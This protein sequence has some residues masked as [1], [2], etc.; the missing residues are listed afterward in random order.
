MPVGIDDG[1]ADARR[2]G[3]EYVGR[4]GIAEVEGAV[5]GDTEAFE[6]C[7]KDSRVGLLEAKPRAVEDGIEAS[8]D[9][10]GLEQAFEPTLGVAH[11]GNGH[12]TGTKGGQRWD[13]TLRDAAIEVPP[14]VFSPEALEQGRQSYRRHTRARHR[15]AQHPAPAARAGGGASF[16]FEVE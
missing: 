15:G 3:A 1:C 12:A 14:L 13:Q 9:A 16:P 10:E 11:D 5:R 2:S 6:G 7:A 4:V 8:E